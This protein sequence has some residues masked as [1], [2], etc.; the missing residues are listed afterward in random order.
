MLG[1]GHSAVFAP[2]LSRRALLRFLEFGPGND[3]VDFVLVEYI[4]ALSLLH[5]TTRGSISK[6]VRAVFPMCIGDENADG[7]QTDEFFNELLS[8]KIRTPEQVD[9][10]ASKEL[11][12]ALPDFISQASCD[13]ASQLLSAVQ[14]TKCSSST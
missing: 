11:G 4:V 6:S 7:T 3:F 10:N 13:K 9:Q 1:L 8:G 5:Y 14:D 12:R 2:L